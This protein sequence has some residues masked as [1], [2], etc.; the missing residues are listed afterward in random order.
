M[1]LGQLARAHLAI[2]E[3]RTV[4]E[5]TGPES[6]L[7]VFQRQRIA[8]IDEATGTVLA[9]GGQRTLSHPD[10]RFR[11]SQAQGPFSELHDEWT[12]LRDVIESN[13]TGTVVRLR[14]GRISL[15]E[16]IAALPQVLNESAADSHR[17]D[18]PTILRHACRSSFLVRLRSR[19]QAGEF[20]NVQGTLQQAIAPL[21]AMNA[22]HPERLQWKLPLAAGC[23][24]SQRALRPGRANEGGP[25]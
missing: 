1:Q 17:L 24:P 2:N 21:E 10:P 19:A 12:F 3:V 13:R 7:D 9:E 14:S 4:L 18:F 11:P 8:E 22:E 23:V 16:A 5:Q 25:R 15:E 6:K 20:A